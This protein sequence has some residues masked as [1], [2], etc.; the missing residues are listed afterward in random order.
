MTKKEYE[1]LLARLPAQPGIMNRGKF[2][3][4]AVMVPLLLQ[5][6]EYHFVLEKR[7]ATIT[8]GGV[9]YFAG[10]GPD[11]RQDEDTRHTVMRETAEE[12]GI[13]DGKIIIERQLDTLVANRG[14]LVDVFIGRLN[15]A[16]LDEL[17]P[18][19]KEL[20]GLFTLPVEYFREHEPE[21]YKVRVEVQPSF[22]DADGKEVVLLPA[23]RLGLPEQYQKPFGEMILPVYVYKT[24][25]GTIWGLTAEIIREVILLAA[26]R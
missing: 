22:R 16:S 4:A 18:E 10:G 24:P 5:D 7:A 1:A 6:G 20:E 26:P 21:E 9:I 25:K 8:Q 15:I 11:P 12:L 14:A 13:E 3:N 23:A 2:F 17:R 19:P